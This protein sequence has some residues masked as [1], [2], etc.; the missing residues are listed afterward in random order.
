MRNVDDI[1]AL[2]EFA[3]IQERQGVGLLHILIY[4]NR[5]IVF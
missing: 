3:R 4:E 5:V 1:R 2:A